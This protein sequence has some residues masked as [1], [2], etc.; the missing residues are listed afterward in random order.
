M[1]ARESV[2]VTYAPAAD[3]KS[4][5]NAAEPEKRTLVSSILSG[6]IAFTVRWAML[7]VRKPCR[8]VAL[9]GRPLVSIA[10]PQVLLIA[11]IVNNSLLFVVF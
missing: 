3:G 11:P 6:L 10:E 2:N 5:E 4:A 7:L 9:G 8:A 1:A